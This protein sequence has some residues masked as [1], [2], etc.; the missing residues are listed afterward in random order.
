MTR[1]TANGNFQISGRTNL[2]TEGGPFEGYITPVIVQLP[3]TS[4]NT[5]IEFTIPGSYSWVAPATTS[6]A[7]IVVVGA[8]G[9][10]G[11]GTNPH[12]GG[13][14]GLAYKNNVTIIPNQTYTI[15]VG[16]RGNA[17][18][19]PGANSNVIY[20]G[21]EIVAASGGRGGHPASYSNPIVGFGGNV[22][23]GDGG[24]RGGRGGGY[25]GTG[26]GYGA[27][28][29]G[30]GG[31]QGYLSGG[32]G[33]I[34]GGSS[35]SGATSGNSPGSGG[36]G[37]GGGAAYSPNNSGSG[38]GGGGGGVGLYGQGPSGSAGNFTNASSAS[39]GTGGSPG[40]QGGTPATTVTSAEGGLY[41]GGGGGGG[42][43]ANGAVRII[44]GTGRY[45]PNIFTTNVT[46]TAG[47]AGANLDV[48]GT[49]LTPNVTSIG[50]NTSNVIGF[51]V[52]A[53]QVANT[54]T[55]YWSINHITTNA[56][57]FVTNN[58][59]FTVTD[60]SI[61]F[62]AFTI[63]STTDLSTEGNETCTVSLRAGSI[64]G[65]VIKTTGTITINDTSIAP[66]ETPGNVEFTVAGTYTWISPS[67]PGDANISIVAIGA[68]GGGSVTNPA[69]AGGG[70]GGLTWVNAIPISA[71]TSY[72]V[73]VGTGSGPYGNPT[74]VGTTGGPS[75]VHLTPTPGTNLILANGGSGAPGGAPGAAGTGGP[76]LAPLI[77]PGYANMGGAPGGA[78]GGTII[79]FTGAGGG[80]AGG[81][82]GPG[83]AGGPTAPTTTTSA[84]S[85][86]PGTGGGGGGGGGG[87][88]GSIGGGGGGVGLYGVPASPS[89]S[90]GGSGG[91]AGIPSG[92]GN[93]GGG[94][95]TGTPGTGG[96]VGTGGTAGAAGVPAGPGARSG[97]GGLYGG[98]SGGAGLNYN[99]EVVGIAPQGAVRI[100]WGGGRTFPNNAA[101]I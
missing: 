28:G 36:A 52:F 8:G 30:A 100:I 75:R 14:G 77:A 43:G 51:T 44:T 21:T 18:T 85:G 37:G 2:I 34:G 95:G 86:S 90:S 92:N 62:P 60:N 69:A 23:V 6:S 46:V 61:S 56:S 11:D 72:S 22:T 88:Y 84:P 78:G 81:Y 64:A 83:G 76:T 101:N 53:P 10:C 68:G 50:E 98:A 48:T 19:Q 31:Y 4:A 93:A 71:S 79:N 63:S 13:G 96:T 55:L 1:L 80:G 67:S 7:S 24:G 54:T 32:G 57:D 15:N 42:L 29:G 47:V 35:G 58:G 38:N 26:T 41:G 91:P 94:G 97:N 25:A 9:A 89:A 65:T 16:G 66:P 17:A 59:N 82:S 49:T 74:P 40:G 39:T 99:T 87:S 73:I 27:G 12:G 45:F 70:G 3:G 20:S 5:Q 33:G